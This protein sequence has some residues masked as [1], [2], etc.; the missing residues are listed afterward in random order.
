MILIIS[1]IVGFLIGRIGVWI[2]T[3]KA[4]RECV[5]ML[6]QIYIQEDEEL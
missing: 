4:E 2:R 1:C 3:K 5:D 6:K